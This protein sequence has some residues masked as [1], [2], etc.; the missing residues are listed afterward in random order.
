MPKYTSVTI[1]DSG[2]TFLVAGTFNGASK[3]IYFNKQDSR[4]SGN[5]DLDTIYI[6][7]ES[8]SATVSI[9]FA[10]VVSPVL[11]N[12]AALIT[13]V[14]GLYDTGGT[15]VVV[16]NLTPTSMGDG[17]KDV[18]VAGT[19]EPLA[20]ISTEIKN[21]AIVA[22]STNTGK[23]YVGGSGVSSSS[24]FPL[25]ADEWREFRI[26]D[27]NKVYIDSDVNGEGVTFDYQN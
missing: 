5:P 24:G 17:S 16:S 23:I 19:A 21:I 18:A 8:N 4:V 11:A 27:L 2:T 22:K 14:E 3:E 20:A 9:E 10:D 26:D 13:F 6:H 1:A 12:Y 25:D 15:A 7:D